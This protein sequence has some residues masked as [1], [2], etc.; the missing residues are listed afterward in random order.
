MSNAELAGKIKIYIESGEC[1][2]CG[3][4]Y[5]HGEDFGDFCRCWVSELVNKRN[6]LT[7]KLVKDFCMEVHEANIMSGNIMYQ[8]AE[9]FK[10][11]W[12]K[13]KHP[14]KFHFMVG[15]I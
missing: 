2:C 3:M 5:T 10:K 15:E 1:A 13:G 6:E 9:R 11:K 8:F 4:G 7:H 14:I 12:E